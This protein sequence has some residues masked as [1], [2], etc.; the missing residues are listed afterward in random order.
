[1]L[2]LLR[3]RERERERG[4]YGPY[5]WYFCWIPVVPSNIVEKF[6]FTPQFY[7]TISWRIHD[8]LDSDAGTSRIG[9]FLL[10]CPSKTGS[11]LEKSLSLYFLRGLCAIMSFV[12]R[13]L[14]PLPPTF[15]Y[16][17]G[18]ETATLRRS[19]RP[20]DQPRKK[21]GSRVREGGWM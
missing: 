5:T 10:L 2:A 15:A 3:E 7:F 9:R 19:R 13:R 4:G 21:G 18:D 8:F 14:K 17:T 20:D 11:S 6:P 12:E 16:E 1:M